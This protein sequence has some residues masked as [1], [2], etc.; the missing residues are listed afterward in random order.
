MKRAILGALIAAVLGSGSARGAEGRTTAVRR[1][2]LR[3]RDVAVLSD[4]R[5]GNPKAIAS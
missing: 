2:W 5:S 4:G 1:L 3:Q